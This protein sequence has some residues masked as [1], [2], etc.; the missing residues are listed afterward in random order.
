MVPSARARACRSTRSASTR[1]SARSA[2]AR[3][4]RSTRPT[5][6]SSNR[7]VAIKTIRRRLGAD[8][9]LRKRFEREAQSAARLNHPNIITVYDYGE[10]QDKIYMAMELLEG[11]DLKQT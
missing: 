5:T 3:W 8:E 1:S 10:E 9:T 7:F 4:A 2:R 11:T 6:R